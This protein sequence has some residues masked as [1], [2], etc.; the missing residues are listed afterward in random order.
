MSF[1]NLPRHLLGFGFSRIII[2][3]FKFIIS[4]AIGKKKVL[5]TA[6]LLT[7]PSRARRSGGGSTFLFCLDGSDSS[8]KPESSSA[9]R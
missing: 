2:I 1:V 3:I 6:G 9:H 5:S 4:P 8:Q 7:E